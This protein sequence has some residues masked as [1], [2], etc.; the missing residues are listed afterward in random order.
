L[1]SPYP[2]YAD[3]LREFGHG[4]KNFEAANSYRLGGYGYVGR[5][6]MSHLR[7]VPPLQP[8]RRDLDSLGRRAVLCA[9]RRLRARGIEDPELAEDFAS[10]A[11]DRFIHH[12]HQ[13]GPHVLGLLCAAIEEMIDRSAGQTGKVK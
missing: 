4:R 3:D 5:T 7:L 6:A 11:M 8:D 12:A 13:G 2:V 9:A 10:M 1:L